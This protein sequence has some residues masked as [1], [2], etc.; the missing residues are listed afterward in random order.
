MNV[1]SVVIALESGCVRT[2]LISE[3][4]ASA[5]FRTSLPKGVFTT[6]STTDGETQE[7]A[8]AEPRP[9]PPPAGL[10]QRQLGELAGVAHTTVQRLE[11]LNRGGLPPNPAETS[12]GAGGRARGL[13]GDLGRTAPTRP[14][15]DGRGSPTRRVQDQ[16]GY[17][18]LAKRK[19]GGPISRIAV[20]VRHECVVRLLGFLGYRLERSTRRAP[21]CSAGLCP[22]VLQAPQS[23]LERLCDRRACP[24][25]PRDLTV[26]QSL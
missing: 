5:R 26:R 16:E 13:N 10:T 2:G 22:A 18:K 17:R 7:H 21:C 23:R 6:R 14:L 25:S 1:R 9:A 19:S 3:D 12:H 8:A 4:V 20:F 24:V 11:S 15:G